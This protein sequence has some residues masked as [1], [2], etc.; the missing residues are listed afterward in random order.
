MNQLHY[1]NNR[2]HHLKVIISMNKICKALEK[3]KKM[4]EILKIK[5]E[6]KIYKIFMGRKSVFNRYL[7]KLKTLKLFI[8]IIFINDFFI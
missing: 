4:K 3:M 2:N 7:L 1:N 8:Y 6:E 5:K